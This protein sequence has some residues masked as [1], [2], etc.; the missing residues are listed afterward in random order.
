MT[1]ANNDR[2]TKIEDHLAR[3]D[4]Y[5]A[6]NEERI[7]RQKATIAERARTGRDTTEASKV[8]LTMCDTL[9]VMRGHRE[10]LLC[11]RSPRAFKP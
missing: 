5:I 4:C 3:T 8:L 6:E 9:T 7:F 10:I 2:L 1:E 11:Q